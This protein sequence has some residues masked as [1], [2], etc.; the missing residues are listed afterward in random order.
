MNGFIDALGGV[1]RNVAVGGQW[2]NMVT[3]PTL[4]PAILA[5]TSSVATIRENPTA[6]P[7]VIT[8]LVKEDGVSSIPGVVAALEAILAAA[9]TVPFNVDTFNTAIAS[10]ETALT[11]AAAT[12]APAPVPSAPVPGVIPVGVV[13]PHP[14]VD[15]GD[16]LRGHLDAPRM[17]QG[18]PPLSGARPFPDNPIPR[19][20]RRW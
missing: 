6:A 1:F 19:A 2:L 14:F 17:G 4:G 13:V 12:V 16:K 11:A 15:W 5:V 3:H 20:G 10:L 7:A 9:T 8:A 18:A